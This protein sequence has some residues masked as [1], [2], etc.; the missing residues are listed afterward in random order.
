MSEFL[1]DENIG[2]ARDSSSLMFQ[3]VWILLKPADTEIASWKAKSHPA[4]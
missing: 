3:R 2:T 1:A 4:L